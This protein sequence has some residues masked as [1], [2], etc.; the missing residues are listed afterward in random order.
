MVIKCKRYAAS[1]PIPARDLRELAGSRYHFTA[2]LAIFVTTSRFTDQSTEFALANNIVRCRLTQAS[3]NGR[4]AAA[5]SWLIIVPPQ[6][7]RRAARRRIVV[8]TDQ[9]WHDQQVASSLSCGPRVGL[10]WGAGVAAMRQSSCFWSSCTSRTVRRSPL[11]I[12][13]SAV[14]YSPKSCGSGCHLA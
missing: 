1:R 14:R 8:G 11:A 3:V 2:D 9:T 12:Q 10:V 5:S 6:R 4:T 7:R 13:Q